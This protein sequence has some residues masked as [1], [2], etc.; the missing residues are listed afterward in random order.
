[1][2]SRNLKIFLMSSLIFISL[3]TF[4]F[5]YYNKTI[6]GFLDTKYEKTIYLVWR[7][8]IN[9][10]TGYGIGDRVR[11]ALCLYQYCK[12]N[13][14]N[15]KIDATDDKCGDYLKNI[16]SDDYNLIKDKKLILLLWHSKYSEEI[17][18]T[19]DD[20]LVKNNTIF[21]FSNY[22]TQKE[23]DSDDKK[24]AKYICQPNNA[25]KLEIDDK[26]NKLPKDFGIQHFRFKDEVFDKDLNEN[27]P[28]F[29]KS[30]E[31]LKNS[32][33]NTDVLM[34]NSNNLKK[35]AKEKL[36]IKTIDC[37]DELCKIAHSGGNDESVKNTLIEFSIIS[38]AK[39]I[40]SYTCY[41]WES[42]FVKW[43]SKIYDIP[44]ENVFLNEN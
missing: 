31:L 42:N 13:N 25:L 22:Y 21:V 2:K 7:N 14:I 18:K 3:S 33:K 30:F 41:D 28:L 16:K 32:F 17:K 23:L 27:N 10:E 4:V 39:Y 24:F 1:M 6:E 5:H 34:S 8:K 15:L 11:G 35:Y 12:E 26:V 36:K 37:D 20:E 38:K 44:F 9:T 19:L 43:P 40:K 29:Q